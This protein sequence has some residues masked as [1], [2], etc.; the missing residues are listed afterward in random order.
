MP[1]KAMVLEKLRQ[2][3]VP[4]KRPEAEPERGEIRFKVVAPTVCRT[5]LCVV[6]GNG[7]DPWL[8]NIADHGD[9]G[10]IARVGAVLRS[11]HETKTATSITPLRNTV[12]KG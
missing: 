4:C 9:V 3:L 5:V 12:G 2:R 8:P 7:P 1:M 6:D 11:G 10:M